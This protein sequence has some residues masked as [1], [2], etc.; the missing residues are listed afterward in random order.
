[1]MSSYF[2]TWMSY[3]LMGIAMFFSI[4]YPILGIYISIGSKYNIAPGERLHGVQF[5]DALTF[6]F[7]LFVVDLDG[8][9]RAF[10]LAVYACRI[11]L[12]GLFLSI[13]SLMLVPLR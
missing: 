7:D 2:W 11:V 4:A 3:H 6:P 10:V 13:L 12:V 5:P 8:A 9:R 1:M